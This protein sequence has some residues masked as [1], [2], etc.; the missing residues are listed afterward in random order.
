MMTFSCI[1]ACAYVSMLALET[2]VLSLEVGRI[3]QTPTRR[4]FLLSTTAAALTST[5]PPAAA[6][7]I[8]ESSSPPFLQAT[9]LATLSISIARSPALKPLRIELFGDDAPESVAFFSNLASGA[10]A[11]VKCRADDANAEICLD[12]ESINVGYENSQVWRLVPDKRIDFGRVDSMFSSRIPPTF[13]AERGAGGI[14]ASARGAVSV[15]RGGG[16]FE[17]TIAPVDNPALEREDLVVV[18]RVMEGDMPFLDEI[19][20]IPTRRDIV[21]IGDVPPLGSS[22]AR[23]CDFTAPDRTC[24]QYKPLKKILVAKASV[25]SLRQ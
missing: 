23:A 8:T 14:K 16:A 10:L 18:G 21:S 13:A 6:A 7:A 15:K 22:F 5:T 19:H 3:L 24:A 20:A 1:V 4:T 11:N 25:E 12:Y 17:F 9:A 2:P